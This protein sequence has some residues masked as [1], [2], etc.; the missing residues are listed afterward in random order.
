MRQFSYSKLKATLVTWIN[1]LLVFAPVGIVAH[2]VAIGLDSILVLVANSI[3]IVPLGG[4]LSTA[5]DEISLYS[6]ELIGA[7]LEF[8]LSNAVDMITA[9]LALRKHEILIVQTSLIGIIL[10][11]L[12]LVLGGAFLAGGFNRIQ[13]KFNL[14]FGCSASLLLTISCASLMVPTAFH[15]AG[16]LEGAGITA[17]SRGIAVLLLLVYAC[18][19]VFQLKTHEHMFTRTSEKTPKG[20]V[21]RGEKPAPA[22]D[23]MATDG[24]FQYLLVPISE[25]E[26]ETPT[27]PDRNLPGNAAV[28]HRQP[29][30]QPQLPEPEEP[31]PEPELTLL[32]ALALLIITVVLVALCVDGLVSNIDLFVSSLKISKVFLGLIVFPAIS[33]AIGLANVVALATRDQLDLSILVTV[34]SSIQVALAMIPFIV[35]LGWGL[36]IDEMNLYFDGFQVVV[37]FF[38]V[39]MVNHP[40]RNGESHYLKGCVMLALYIIIA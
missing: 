33:N 3:A 8:T 17:L 4:L 28:V 32:F 9:I 25:E 40:I 26:E 12:L 21:W 7:L 1:C 24:R 19:L 36:G 10:N 15:M 16:N 27:T 5:S 14:M 23:T 20:G 37:L 38:S 29:H 11:R 34:G 31:E 39:L 22:S 13:Q 18:Y 30:R 35:I 2:Y 6:G